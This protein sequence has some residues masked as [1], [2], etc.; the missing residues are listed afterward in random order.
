MS[1][2]TLK[3]DNKRKFVD[4]TS[5]EKLFYYKDVDYIEQYKFK[6]LKWGIYTP[7]SELLLSIKEIEKLQKMYVDVIFIA[8]E[9]SESKFRVDFACSH[10]DVGLD[11]LSIDNMIKEYINEFGLSESYRELVMN[12]KYDFSFYMNFAYGELKMRPDEKLA[13]TLQVNEISRQDGLKPYIKIKERYGILVEPGIYYFT[14]PGHRYRYIMPEIDIND[15]FNIKVAGICHSED[16]HPSPFAKLEY[17]AIGEEHFDRLKEIAKNS[18]G[19]FNQ[20]RYN[21]SGETKEFKAIN[22]DDVFNGLDKTVQEYERL[23]AI[24]WKE[25]FHP[26]LEAEELLEGVG[27]ENISLKFSIPLFG[28]RGGSY[29]AAYKL[30]N[31]LVMYYDRYNNYKR[32]EYDMRLMDYLHINT[33]ENLACGI[34]YKVVHKVIDCVDTKL[35]ELF[36][37]EVYTLYQE[38]QSKNEVANG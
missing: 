29:K 35:S 18:G 33:T 7:E 24:E 1:G 15:S 32:E 9:V 20:F 8:T 19:F 26:E 6:H 3:F 31:K 22:L 28:K 30:G 17:L 14:I 5:P 16:W 21:P 36:T 13:F 38:L 10:N 34:P 2:L 12:S 4:I 27:L 25:I 37:P 11:P 23:E